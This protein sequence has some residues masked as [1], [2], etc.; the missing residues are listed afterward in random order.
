M[1]VLGHYGKENAAAIFE[2]FLQRM[3]GYPLDKADSRGNTVLLLAYVKANASLC[4]CEGR[5][6]PG[7]NQGI[8]FQ[9]PGCIQAVAF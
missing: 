9:P 1:H 3:P 6:S 8:I 2:L 4:C 7:S 5:G